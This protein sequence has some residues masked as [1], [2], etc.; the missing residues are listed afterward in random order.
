MFLRLS[1]HGSGQE[2]SR[3]RILKKNQDKAF[4]ESLACFLM[5]RGALRF[6]AVFPLIIA[7]IL[8]WRY[9]HG[10]GL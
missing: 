7:A 4:C 2:R 3:G 8:I 1:A 6:G 9:E 10:K 5:R